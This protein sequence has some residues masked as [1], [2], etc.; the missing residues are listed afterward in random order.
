MSC[1]FHMDPR[2]A[3]SS[4]REVG[5]GINR[6]TD[7]GTMDSHSHITIELIVHVALVVAKGVAM[8]ANGQQ[9]C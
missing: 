6:D 2:C 5:A 7:K 8:N 9:F 1:A 3:M 4:T